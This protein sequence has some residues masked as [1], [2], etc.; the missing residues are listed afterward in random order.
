[1]TEW[2]TRLEEWTLEWLDNHELA[3]LEQARRNLE[4]QNRSS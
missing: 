4:N 2:R 1:M 3:L